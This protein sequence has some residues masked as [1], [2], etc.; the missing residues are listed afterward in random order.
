MTAVAAKE[1]PPVWERLLLICWYLTVFSAP[2]GDCL[3]R[4][5][6]PVGGHFFLFRGMILLTCF[7]Y[8]IYLIH[9]R[10][11]PLRGLSQPEKCFV[12]LAVCMLVYGLA[13]V[14]WAS[15][16]GAW[17]SKFFTMC[18]MF[19]LVFL[20]LKLCREQKVL[21]N[22]M[23]IMGVTVLITALGG[24]A[25]MWHGPFFD[26]P[27]RD[28]SYVFFNKAFYAPIFSYYNPNGLSAYLLFTLE[29][30]YLY[31][32]RYWQASAAAKDRRLLW[33]LSAGMCLTVFLCC[34]DGGRLSLLSIPI[35]LLGL[36]IW[37]LLRYKKG[38]W[39]FAAFAL[40]LS[41][42]YVGENYPQVKY[43]VEQAAVAIQQHFG[44]SDDVSQQPELPAPPEKNLHGTLYTFTPSVTETD[45]YESL[46]HSDGVR[47][48][49]L[50]DC[51]QMIRES[52]GLGIGLGNVESRLREMDNSD[53]IYAA[54][55]FVIEVLAEFGIFAF[56]PLL[57]LGL[58]ILLTLWR[59]T[60][61]S[62][63]TGEKKR[64]AMPLLLFFTLLTYPLLSTANSSS[65]GIQAM[66]LYLAAVMLCAASFYSERDLK[67]K[68]LFG[69]EAV[70]AD[71][72]GS[73]H[74]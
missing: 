25:E 12:L 51:I 29:C 68:G 41:F 4:V 50:K 19:A 63:R 67:S 10:E 8:L 18:Q 59:E 14:A 65:W 72:K 64:L 60:S 57:A 44:A 40:T 58:S 52:H 70:P 13:S 39:V 9:Q 26:T 35:F 55:C 42:I 15:S 69:R 56:L 46:S 17:F 28:Y 43:R 34:A 53:G 3:L 11:N 36:A 30:L 71:R 20:F 66:W 47:V 48:T 33:A 38:L 45:A 49:L 24:L 22:T 54:H 74:G 37:L 21:H 27:Y 31:M 16:I 23:G 32:A 7:V 5:E 73:L 6:L 62:V 2:F 61:A 1:K